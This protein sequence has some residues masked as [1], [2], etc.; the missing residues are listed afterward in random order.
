MAFY[1]VENKKPNDIVVSTSFISYVKLKNRLNES[2]H[3]Q[4]NELFKYLNGV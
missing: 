1:R 3:Q 4:K 2:S